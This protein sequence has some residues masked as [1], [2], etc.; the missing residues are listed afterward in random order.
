MDK[1]FRLI[2]LAFRANKVL[3]GIKGMDAITNKKAFL[4]VLSDDASDN[5]KKKVLD[6]CAY[7]QVPVKS[8]NSRN[9]LS[10]CIGKKDI[11]M[12]AIIEEGFA[13]SILKA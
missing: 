5:T 11:V 10:K 9:E 13:N 8:V 4:V 12:I 7:Y 1:I 6:K 3:Y 2:G